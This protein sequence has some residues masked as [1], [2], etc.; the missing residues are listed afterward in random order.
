MLGLHTVYVGCRAVGVVSVV[1]AGLYHLDVGLGQCGFLGK[2]LAQIVERHVEVAVEEPA[3]EAE[4]KHVA[5]LEHRLGFHTAVGEAVLHHL[6][7]GACHYA[8]GIDVHLCQGILGGECGLLKVG[9]A[10]RVG[11]YNNGS[12]GLG[13]AVLCLQCS[14]IHGYQHV[15]QVARCIHLARADMYL[16]SRH[17]RKASLRGTYVGRIVGEGTN[18]VTYG[19]RYGRK[20]ISRQLHT[21]ARVAG[22]AHDHL[23]AL[24][25]DD[26][27]THCL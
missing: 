10:E 6:C 27:F 22:E 5:A 3:H 8:V 17:A 14:S 12:V 16:E 7:D 15:A 11:I 1:V 13:I 20:D 18:V 25:Y 24:F 23:V 19:S 2:L 26:L 4:G 21:V 9:W